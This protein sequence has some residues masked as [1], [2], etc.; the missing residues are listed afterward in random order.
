[1]RYWW[2]NQNQTYDHEVVGGFLWSPKTRRDGGRNQFYEN[3]REVRPRDVVFSFC[4][5]HIKAVGVARGTAQTAVKPAFGAAGASWSDEGWL[6]PVEFGEVERPVRP[7]DHI[8]RLRPLL[9]EKYSPLQ[10]DG[11]GLQSVYLAAVPEPLALALIDLMGNSYR[12]VWSEF[13]SVENEEADDQHLQATTERTDIGPVEKRQ[14]VRA[15]RGQG[16]FRKNLQIYEHSCRLTMVSDTSHLR[17]SHIKPWRDSDDTEKLDGCNGLLP[18]PH[19]DHLFDRG[20]ISFSDEGDVLVS[21]SLPRTILDAWGLPSV[22]NVGPF[23]ERQRQYLE[24]HR[25]QVFRN[26]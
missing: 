2:V 23:N 14:L 9:P 7:K 20:Y 18:S 5:T 10:E 11:N 21:S 19:V 12:A 4:D 25:S 16:A 1:M 22:R 24:H 26:Q 3:M 8:E 17:A 13:A 15:R 6:V